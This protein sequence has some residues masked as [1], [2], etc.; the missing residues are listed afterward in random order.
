MCSLG[1]SEPTRL[2]ETT[3]RPG[4]D[5]NT[6]VE[7][8]MPSGPVRAS[9]ASST[10]SPSS[11]WKRTSVSVSSIPVGPAARTESVTDAPTVP[12]ITVSKAVTPSVAGP[13]PIIEGTSGGGPATEGT[14]VTGD[15]GGAAFALRGEGWVLQGILVA[16]AV[17]EK[18]PGEIVAFGNLS[19]IADLSLYRGRIV[20]VIDPMA[21][22]V[23]VAV[24]LLVLAAGFGL[25]ILSRRRRAR[26]EAPRG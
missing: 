3:V 12:L 7:R 24:A 6:N 10:P 17:H 25:A 18:Q 13:P 5:G 22:A 19:E 8:A 9:T 2:T 4:R 1:V 21:G 23:E 11:T 14:A 26:T 20:A 16:R 15:S